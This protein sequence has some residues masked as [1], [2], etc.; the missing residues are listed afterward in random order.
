MV[1]HDRC[2]AFV[3]VRRFTP[4]YPNPKSSP[5]M[6]THP[7]GGRRRGGSREA[8]S[9]TE[10]NSD[11]AA[12]RLRPDS[13]SEPSPPP[14]GP[15]GSPCVRVEPQAPHRFHVGATLREGCVVALCFIPQLAPNQTQAKHH[16]HHICCVPPF[17]PQSY[18]TLLVALSFSPYPRF[19]DITYPPQKDVGNTHELNGCGTPDE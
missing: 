2:L 3:C 10:T 4:P 16:R 5:D 8:E 7:S 13:S 9:Q 17:S 6:L 11:K 18:H 14:Q 1:G 12:R 15:S 19:G